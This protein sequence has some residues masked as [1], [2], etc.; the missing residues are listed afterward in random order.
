MSTKPTV[1]KCVL[2]YSGGLDTSIIVPWLKSNYN[3]EVICFCADLGQ[4]EE[5]E[6]LEAK[7]LASGASKCYVFDLREEFLRD[8]VFP[9][10]QAGAIYERD[11]LLGTSMAR[12]LIADR[13]EAGGSGRIGRGRCR[14][15]WRNRQGQR[16]SAL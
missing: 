16:P 1:K 7:A 10:L 2:A 6:G 4:A 13:Q 8:Y 14:G 3:C 9:T 15:A 11:Y 5:L 12:P